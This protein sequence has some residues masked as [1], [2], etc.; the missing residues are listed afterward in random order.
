[1]SSFFGASELALHVT[2]TL[3]LGFLSTAY[4]IN[5]HR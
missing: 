3:T 4:A 5:T 2:I 1:M